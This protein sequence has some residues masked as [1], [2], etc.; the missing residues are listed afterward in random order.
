[1]FVLYLNNIPI[2]YSITP[3]ASKQRF[4]VNNREWEADG[5]GAASSIHCHSHQADTQLVSSSAALLPRV[6]SLH[7]NNV[8]FPPLSKSK[9]REN[10]DR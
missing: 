10:T 2:R 1:M 8:Y 5:D 7:E 9:T 6:R 3:K 4:W